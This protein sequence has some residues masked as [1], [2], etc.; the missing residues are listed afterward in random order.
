MTEHSDPRPSAEEPGRAD[1]DG[2]RAAGSGSGEGIDHAWIERLLKAQQSVPLPPEVAQSWDAALAA[3]A[4]VAAPAGAAAQR[5]PSAPGRN[6]AKRPGPWALRAAA[7]ALAAAVVGIVAV[8]V[9]WDQS[10][11]PSEGSAP[12]AEGPPQLAAAPALLA[13]G[14]D[15]QPR[16]LPEQVASAMDLAAASADAR[17][18][19]SP[20]ERAQSTQARCAAA[21]LHERYQVIVLDSAG[22]RGDP[23]LVVIARERSGLRLWVT[24]V[25]VPCQPTRP[26]VLYDAEVGTAN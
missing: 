6:T 11:P 19:P 1:P 12:L 10:Q 7:A 2:M 24:V 18:T 16:R 4:S 13:T 5:L 22:F 25:S 3:A 20:Q 8:S 21:V 14:T 15:Y 23:A 26:T 9:G 17:T